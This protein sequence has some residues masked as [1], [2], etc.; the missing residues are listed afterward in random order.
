VL[1]TLRGVLNRCDSVPKL[2]AST[3]TSVL[4]PS[5]P[6]LIS[7][8]VTLCCGCVRRL[9]R[10][11][12]QATALGLGGEYLVQETVIRCNRLKS[13]IT[14]SHSLLLFILLSLLTSLPSLS[15][16]LSFSRQVRNNIRYAVEVCSIRRMKRSPF[17]PVF[18]L[19]LPLL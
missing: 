16:S 19:N 10:C 6:P 5:L 11:V 3:D 13:L 18:P 15:L 2:L 9:E 12:V 7:L 4:P 8:S 14:V 17:S 1:S